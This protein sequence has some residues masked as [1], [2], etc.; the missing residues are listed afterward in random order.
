MKLHFKNVLYWS[1]LIVTLQCWGFEKVHY[2]L[3][4]EPID[5]VIPC[6]AKDLPTLE[7]CIS[8]IRTYGE[9]IRRI[10]IISPERLSENAE[11]YDE[12]KF[13]FSK[14][15]IVKEI[16]G[17]DRVALDQFLASSECKVG[18]IYQQVLKFYAPFVI[19]GISSNVLL[20]D[21]DTIFLRPVSFMS[22]E[23]HG[24][25]NIGREY[26]PAYFEHAARLIPGFRKIFVNRSGICHHMLFQQ[27]VLEDL[28]HLVETHH[29]VKMWKALCHCLDHKELFKPSMSEYEIYFNF[30]FARTDQVKIRILRWKNDV[31]SHV[32]KCQEAG[33]HYVSCHRWLV[34][35]R[36]SQELSGKFL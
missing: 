4:T 16:F 5:V 25:Y 18:W 27:A 7:L 31:L 6:V 36:L 17:E 26:Q 13:P 3:S 10:I 14:L 11:W 30:V 15:D 2:N 24:L 19:P 8:G 29:Q 9:N 23:G 21:A 32:K 22:K 28:F 33:V 1:L 35:S 12:K 34:E 20:L